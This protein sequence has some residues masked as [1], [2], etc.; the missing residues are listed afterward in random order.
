[1]RNSPMARRA[2]IVVSMVALL[3][4]PAPAHAAAI[5]HVIEED[6]S[7]WSSI[8]ITSTDGGQSSIYKLEALAPPAAEYPTTRLTG[9]IKRWVTGPDG[10]Q[11]FE[12]RTLDYEWVWRDL[13]PYTKGEPFVPGFQP[14][15]DTIQQRDN[16]YDGFP[17]FG[18]GLDTLDYA[19]PVCD[20]VEGRFGSPPMAKCT[21]SAVD[22]FAFEN[23]PILELG[24]RLSLTGFDSDELFVSPRWRI[25]VVA[26]KPT[27]YAYGLAALT[28][29]VEEVV[30][31]CRPGDDGESCGRPYYDLGNFKYASHY[32]VSGDWNIPAYS[33]VNET[34]DGP[35]CE[36]LDPV[37]HRL[38]PQRDTHLIYSFEA[39]RRGRLHWGSD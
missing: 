3:A 15:V 39:A 25:E 5:N 38:V 14:G 10:Q 21:I 11:R 20:V 8:T 16:L 12:R 32:H 6:G 36:S 9:V 30:T 22:R 13:I 1:M 4:L 37:T 28:N 17:G 29:L 31:D 24:M 26:E 27:Q 19:Q 2:L 23:L 35:S 7:A 18:D 33:C 34:Y